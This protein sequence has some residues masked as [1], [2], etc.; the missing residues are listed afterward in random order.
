MRIG[1]FNLGKVYFVTVERGEDL[2]AV[3][4]KAVEELKIRQGVV[5][6]GIGVQE[7]CNLYEVISM[8][9]PPQK[10][11][12]K[13]GG[14]VELVAVNGNIIEGAIHMHAVVSTDKGVWA[15]HVE[16]GNKSYITLQMI[17]AELDGDTIVR[18]PNPAG[19]QVIDFE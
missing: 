13:M 7:G 8:D 15:G 2:L 16:P 5:L 17:I 11:W 1:K 6:C 18:K 10:H 14:A 12:E 19:G 9:T 3:M 4:Q